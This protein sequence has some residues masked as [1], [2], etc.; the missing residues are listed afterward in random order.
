MRRFRIHEPDARNSERL[1][2][3]YETYVGLVEA[4]GPVWPRMG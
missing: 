3:A 2:E 1:A 4:L